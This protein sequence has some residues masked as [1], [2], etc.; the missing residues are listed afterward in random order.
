MYL[1]KLETS[2]FPQWRW[3]IPKRFEGATLKDSPW[4]TEQ[5]LTWYRAAVADKVIHASGVFCGVGI[6]AVGGHAE[7]EEFTTALLTDLTRDKNFRKRWPR[8]SP[9]ML[10]T[11]SNA[12]LN[13]DLREDYTLVEYWVEPKI[14]VVTDVGADNKWALTN[15]A[16]LFVSRYRRKLVTMVCLPREV[17]QML[18]PST[19]QPSIDSYLAGI[20]EDSTITVHL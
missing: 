1:P 13:S 9:T 3:S 19:T 6:T 2:P 16:N 8:S 4:L 12:E 5:L 17:Y 20:L 15:L 11:V 10:R 7:C 14:L 18:W